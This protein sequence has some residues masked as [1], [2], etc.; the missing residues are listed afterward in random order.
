MQGYEFDVCY[1]PGKHNIVA[2]AL[3]R[4]L[5]DEDALQGDGVDSAILTISSPVPLLI[6]ELQ[7]FFKS[8]PT[9][10]EFI[11]GFSKDE[12]L[13]DEVLVRNNLLFFCDR[14]VIPTVIM[15]HNNHFYFLVQLNQMLDMV[16]I[17]VRRILTVTIF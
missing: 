8:D 6:S 14:L 2:D 4:Q 15:L 17:Q 3:S 7:T 9:G 12:K 11:E 1:K 5:D 10:R 13:T 16:K